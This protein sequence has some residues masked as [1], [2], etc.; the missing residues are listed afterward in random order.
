MLP[1]VPRDRVRLL[2]WTSD[3]LMLIDANTLCTAGLYP[4]SR[5]YATAGTENHHRG[6]VFYAET[7][8]SYASCVRRA[9]TNR[10]ACERTIKSYRFCVI[11]RTWR[12]R[13]FPAP[14][15]RSHARAREN[16]CHWLSSVSLTFTPDITRGNNPCDSPSS[17]LE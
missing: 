17:E 1:L 14:F 5:G 11:A 9:R 3:V 15:R 6:P 10:C 12:T 8:K 2:S 16:P 4:C 7:R 13:L